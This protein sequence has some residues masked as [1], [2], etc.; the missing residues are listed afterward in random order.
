MTDNKFQALNEYVQIEPVKEV[1][2]KSKI[3]VSEIIKKQTAVGIVVTVGEG[4][5]LAN[6]TKVVPQVKVGDKILYN[7]ALLDAM[8]Y[9]DTIIYIINA[10]A[11]YGRLK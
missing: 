2:K 10:M 4:R 3:I 6:G 9:G 11:I 7:P 8:D 5:L 1:K